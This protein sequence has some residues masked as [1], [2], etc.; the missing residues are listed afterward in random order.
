MKKV[1]AI[2]IEAHMLKVMKKEAKEVGMSLSEYLRLCMLK[3]RENGAGKR[4]YDKV[5]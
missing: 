4:I 5:G 1:F 3:G 2:R